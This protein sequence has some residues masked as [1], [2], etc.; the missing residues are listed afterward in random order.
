MISDTLVKTS[1]ICC[2]WL[3]TDRYGRYLG[4]CDGGIEK[5]IPFNESINYELIT[6]GY[7][8]FYDGGKECGAFKTGFMEAQKE[9]RG[10]F[11]QDLGGFKEP[12]LWRKTKNND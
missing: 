9:G 5:V 12:R 3:K 1:Y 4:W 6:G 11:N 7:A 8:W 2:S 10:L